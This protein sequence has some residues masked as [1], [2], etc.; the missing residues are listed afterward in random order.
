VSRCHPRPGGKEPFLRRRLDPHAL[1]IAT[2]A[3]YRRCPGGGYAPL[4]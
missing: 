1:K 3:G 2:D 4:S